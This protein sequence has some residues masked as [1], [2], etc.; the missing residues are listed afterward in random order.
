[1]ADTIRYTRT[2]SLDLV[3]G[4]TPNPAVKATV[5]VTLCAGTHSTDSTDWAITPPVCQVVGSPRELREVARQ[6]C[7]SVE[8]SKNLCTLHV[9]DSTDTRYAEVIDGAYTEAQE[10]ELPV[11][12]LMLD[13]IPREL[14]AADA[15]LIAQRLRYREGILRRGGHE[16]FNAC[17]PTHRLPLAVVVAV[18]TSAFTGWHAEKLRRYVH[19][20]AAKLGAAVVY[21]DD[22]LPADY[23]DYT[24]CT[25]LLPS[26]SDE[27]RQTAVGG[28]VVPDGYGVVVEPGTSTVRVCAPRPGVAG[29]TRVATRVADVSDDDA[30]GEDT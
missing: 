18:G 16:V 2:T 13:N 7:R 27:D 20:T 17:N 10:L 3:C 11:L 30:P 6:L 15:D 9:L 5:A 4:T 28:V 29:L 14:T 19:R 22:H 26:A 24:T 12:H 8:L 21:L 1:M 25:W 23:T